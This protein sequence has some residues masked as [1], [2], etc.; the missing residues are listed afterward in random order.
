MEEHLTN[1]RYERKYIITQNKLPKLLF[2]LYSNNFFK[3]F[4][5]R[6]INNLYY[7][8]FNFSSLDNNVEGLSSRKKYRIRWYGDTFKTSKKIIEIKIKEE[9]LN[10]KKRLNI[11]N[12]ILK[13]SSS[14]NDFHQSIL[15]YLISK[16]EYFFHTTLSCKRPTLINEYNRDYFFSRK[17]HIR[18]TIDNKLKYFSPITKLN[19][20]ENFIIVEVKYDKNSDFINLFQNL[21]LTRYSKYAKGT[22]QTSSYSP[23]Y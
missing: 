13:N 8:D 1:F 22:I 18:V 10:T 14:I 2:E 12:H 19:F 5:V 11:G 6:K 7:D 20:S 16:N 15:N 23:Y 3:L 17:N 4:P 9:F 21:K